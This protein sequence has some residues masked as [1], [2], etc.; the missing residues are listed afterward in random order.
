MRWGVD[1]SRFLRSLPGERVRA[2]FR[3]GGGL[4]VR[5]KTSSSQSLIRDPSVYAQAEESSW[6]A[7][8]FIF[9][10]D[11]IYKLR[12]FLIITLAIISLY[13]SSY[14]G[15]CQRK[16]TL[17]AWGIEPGTQLLPTDY[18]YLVVCPKRTTWLFLAPAIIESIVLQKTRSVTV[19]DGHDE[20]I[21]SYSLSPIY[22][23]RLS[24]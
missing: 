12:R 9:V 23:E 14:V 21:I 4:V 17:F 1:G 8:H 6:L 13:V 19:Y 5:S 20:L 10:L 18:D 24:R 15:L 22:F 7:D 2:A 11:A 3:T 16:S